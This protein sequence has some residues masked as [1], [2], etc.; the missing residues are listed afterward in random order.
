MGI[1]FSFLG[2]D[3]QIIEEGLG[4]RTTVFDDPLEPKPPRWHCSHRC[5]GIEEVFEC[6]NKT[7]SFL[8]S[9]PLGLLSPGLTLY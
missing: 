5:F 2:R 8:F 3:F 7:K 6:P 9:S 1:L 4:G